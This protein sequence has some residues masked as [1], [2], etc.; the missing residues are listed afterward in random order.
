MSSERYT[1]W[2]QAVAKLQDAE[3]QETKIVQPLV[4]QF[5]QACLHKFGDLPFRG[6]PRYGLRQPFRE[7][8]E[9]VRL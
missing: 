3:N 7:N 6:Y 9:M 4:A 2:Q 8:E 1:T 5:G